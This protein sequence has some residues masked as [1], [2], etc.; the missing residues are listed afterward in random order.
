[1]GVGPLKIEIFCSFSR[2]FLNFKEFMS[3]DTGKN[4][5]VL[6]FLS[7]RLRQSFIVLKWPHLGFH[8]FWLF[9]REAKRE[10]R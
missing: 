9:P 2:I 3:L 4:S 1:M 10:G 6:F 7:N 8:H 5:T